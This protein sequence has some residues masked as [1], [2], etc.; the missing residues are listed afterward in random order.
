M[1]GLNSLSGLNN[2]NV[3]FRPTIELNAPRTGD[4]NQPQQGADAVPVAAPQ[5]EKT[6][7]K[8]VV[9]QLDVLL[10]GA[11]SK[12]VSSDAAN[13][14]T[15]ISQKLVNKELLTEKEAS[16]LESLA[17]DAA[18]KLKA[19]D[20]FSGRELA[21]A[22]MEDKKTGETVWSKGFFFL[23]STAKAVKS[24]IEAQQTLSMELGKFNERLA[25]APKDLVDAKLQDQ[26]TELQFQCD[27]R[28]SEIDSIVFRMYDLTQQDAV[29]RGIQDPKITTLLDA[30]FNELMPREA[31]MMHGT[32]EAF[33]KLDE[34]ITRQMRPLI[35]KLDAF[36]A[37]GSKVLSHEDI[38]SL[39]RDMTTM[40]NAIANVRENG[41]EITHIGNDTSRA[42]ESTSHSSTR[43]RRFLTTLRRGSTTRRTPPR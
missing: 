30:T 37:D 4:A 33:E 15:T 8:S 39:K 34:N 23:N 18:A 9:R 40:K 36:T 32:A 41:I 29:K 31:I 10:L 13:N 12:S 35:E 22:L 42:P 6:E 14:V 24:A 5:P 28:A 1:S 7:A 26:F 11:A 19:L 27:R 20:K 43:W 3:D 2:V 38:L 25:Q 16:K 21:E 17:T